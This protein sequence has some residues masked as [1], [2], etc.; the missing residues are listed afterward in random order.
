MKTF[1]S[2]YISVFPIL[3]PPFPLQRY[4]E[5]ISSEQKEALYGVLRVHFHAKIGPEIRRELQNSKS[6][7]EETPVPKDDMD[8]D[9]RSVTSE[10]IDAN[11]QELFG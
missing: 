5:D 6:R 4:K 1:D 11:Y 8:E 3:F 2:K 9:L 7:D 10:D